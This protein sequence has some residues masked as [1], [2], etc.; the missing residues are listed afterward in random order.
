VEVGVAREY[1]PAQ[2]YGELFDPLVG[3]ALGYAIRNARIP[4]F[5]GPMWVTSPST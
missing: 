5:V 4:R 2:K 1:M 3:D